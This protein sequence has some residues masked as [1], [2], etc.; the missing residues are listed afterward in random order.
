MHPSCAQAVAQ[1]Y[2]TGPLTCGH[3]VP[4]TLLSLCCCHP[5]G[6]TCST[7]PTHTAQQ[8]Q[9]CRSAAACLSCMHSAPTGCSPYVFV[10]KGGGWLP[11]PSLE[12]AELLDLVVLPP[13]MDSWQAAGDRTLGLRPSRVGQGCAE[14]SATI[15]TTTAAGYSCTRAAENTVLPRPCCWEKDRLFRVAE[16]SQWSRRV[17]G[18]HPMMPASPHL[19]LLHRKRGRKEGPWTAGSR[20]T[21]ALNPVSK[22]GA[23]RAPTPSQPAWPWQ[24]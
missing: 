9:G 24:H 23:R 18:L 7:Q 5:Q 4:M 13:V 12:A 14:C 11:P 16:G 19:L 15:G 10:R 6:H 20:A 17:T 21:A 1:A 8:R 3:P 2:C 22:Q